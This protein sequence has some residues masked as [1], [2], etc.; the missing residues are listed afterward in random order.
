MLQQSWCSH[1]GQVSPY[2]VTPAPFILPN[3]SKSSYKG[4]PNPSDP[5]QIQL[6]N[7]YGCFPYKY[8]YGDSAADK[9]GYITTDVA[10][11]TADG[12]NTVKSGIRYVN[13]KLLSEWVYNHV[14]P[15]FWTVYEYRG[16]RSRFSG[17]KVDGQRWGCTIF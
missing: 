5:D 8:S 1:K 15:E 16:P 11:N 4:T 3:T 7:P 10:A 2:I 6:L 14:K 17:E 9:V 12:A 13:D